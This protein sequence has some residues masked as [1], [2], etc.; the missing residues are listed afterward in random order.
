MLVDVVLLRHEGLKLPREELL[1]T[2]PLRA[3][4]SVTVWPGLIQAALGFP[5]SHEPAHGSTRLTLDDCRL[6]RLQ[7]DAFILVGWEWVGMHWQRQRAPQAWWCRLVQSPAAMA[8]GTA[9]AQVHLAADQGLVP[10]QVRDGRASAPLTI[11][12]SLP[13]QP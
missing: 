1:G 3:E 12:T 11:L 13:D 4:L 2:A 6:R 9:A 5:W 10:T 8:S 7:G